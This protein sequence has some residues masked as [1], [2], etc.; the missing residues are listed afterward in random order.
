MVG[1]LNELHGSRAN[2]RLILGRRDGVLLQRLRPEIAVQ[3]LGGARATL[4]IRRLARL[5]AR[6]CDVVYSGTN[7]RNLATL[8]ALRLVPKARRPRAIISEHTTP[9]AYLAS[10]KASGLRRGAMRALYPGAAALAVPAPGLGEAWLQAL[11]LESPRPV[12]VPNP[13]LTASDLALSDRVAGGTGPARDLT[14]VLAAGRLHSA[15]GFDLLIS[16]FACAAAV[17]P[18]L[19]LD[20]HGEGDER[21]ALQAQIDALALHGRVRLCGHTDMLAERIAG[22]GL[23]VV[24]SR[25]EGFGNV[26]IEALAMGTPVLATNCPGPVGLLARVPGAGRVVATSDPDAM[27]HAITEMTGAPDYLDAAAR[28]GP[29]LARGYTTAAAARVFA[30]LLDTIVAAPR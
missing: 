3:D 5:L 6:D 11:S 7:A 19:R 2:T 9:R 30:D 29:D 21:T 1:L 8:A 27:C 18:E 10:A 26:V 24:P 25:R 12:H 22:A 20:I 17:R 23:F 13:I 15:K 28:L 16:A 14:K 4:S